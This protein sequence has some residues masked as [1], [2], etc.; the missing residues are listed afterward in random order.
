LA[1]K[2]DQCVSPATLQAIKVMFF[3]SRNE[4][5][6][7]GSGCYKPDW[8]I[9]AR[10]HESGDVCMV[11]TARQQIDEVSSYIDM[12][13]GIVAAMLCQGKKDGKIDGVMPEET[14][15]D[16][17]QPL[18]GAADAAADA[19]IGDMVISYAG[20]ARLA[21]DSA[22]S[23][24]VYRSDVELKINGKDFAIHL[25]NSPIEAGDLLGSGT[26]WLSHEHVSNNKN[27]NKEDT[28]T[29]AISITYQKDYDEKNPEKLRLNF[30][31]RLGYFHTDFDVFGDDGVVDYNVGA[32][33]T[34]DKTSPLYGNYGA[35]TEA[36]AANEYAERMAYVVYD[37]YPE[38]GVGRMSY[39]VN[40]GGKYD[41]TARGFVFETEIVDGRFQGCGLAGA[42]TSEL[43]TGI[44]IR[45]SLYEE[46][47]IEPRGYIRPLACTDKSGTKVWEQCFFRDKQGKFLVDTN[48]TKSPSGIDFIEIGNTRV[49]KPQQRPTEGDGKFRPPLGDAGTKLPPKP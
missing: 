9:L 3:T 33:F 22:T 28:K 20:V 23:R 21:D 45:K 12:V 43:G 37:G 30:E 24:P 34:A 16:F 7:G 6:D 26:I 41:E 48:R 35:S 10:D 42:T 15:L 8:G 18:Q 32:D 17:T 19:S 13:S 31:M 46:L 27:T 14:T 44:S 25:V 2:E 38:V 47:D 11:G 40:F 36:S 4:D 49:Q 39:W 5:L 1:G 29:K